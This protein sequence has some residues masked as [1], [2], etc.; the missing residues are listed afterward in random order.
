MK[1]NNKAFVSTVMVELL[2]GLTVQE[3]VEFHD[4]DASVPYSGLPLW[5][6]D[7]MPRIDAEQRWLELWHKHQAAVALR[8]FH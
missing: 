6:T 8:A 5:P 7:D 3:S 4:I 2:E 1:I